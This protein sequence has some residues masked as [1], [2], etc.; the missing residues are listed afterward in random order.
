M[1][2]TVHSIAIIQILLVVFCSQSTYYF[3]RGVWTH[4]ATC[5]FSRLAPRTSRLTTRASR[6]A[7][8]CTLCCSSSCTSFRP[9]G[10]TLTINKYRYHHIYAT[11]QFTIQYNT[12]ILFIVEYS[13][14]L[15]IS[16]ELFFDLDKYVTRT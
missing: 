7:P 14:Q 9:V 15:N 11:I 12:I 6:R 16:Y 5:A 10:E 3:I 8:G 2:H 4:V 13:I 1:L